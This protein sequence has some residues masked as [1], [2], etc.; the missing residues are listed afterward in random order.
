VS[1]C[2]ENGHVTVSRDSGYMSSA[3]RVVP[4]GGDCGWRVT[5]RRGQRVQL[6]LAAFGGDGASS[7]TAAAETDTEVQRVID[8]GRSR[9]CHDVGSVC[10]GRRHPLEICGPGQADRRPSHHTLLYL[11]HSNNVIVRLKPASSLQHLSTF[12]IKYKGL[13]TY[14]WRRRMTLTAILN[15]LS[16]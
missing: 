16:K 4:G 9:T 5:A 2:R 10:D 7:E 6:T 1:E 3:T 11:S 8:G 15:H 12:V 13:L 14:F